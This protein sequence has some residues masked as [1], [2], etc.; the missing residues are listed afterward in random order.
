[1]AK[2]K[3]T[4]KYPL[5][6][7]SYTAYKEFIKRLALLHQ[8]YPSLLETTL[9]NIFT[10]RYIGNKTHGDMAEIGITEF[11]NNFLYDYDCEHVGKEEF[12]SKE[13]DEDI[14]VKPLFDNDEGLYIPISLKA[15]G[16]GPLQLSTDKVENPKDGLYHQIEK[17]CKNNV[18]DT[19][20]KINKVF[21]LKGFKSM[22]NV[23]PIIY[24][25]KENDGSECNI[26]TFNLAKAIRETCFI[27]HVK[28]GQKF[29]EKQ[30]KVITE[31]KSKRKKRIYPIFLFLN[32]DYNYICEVRYGGKDANALQRGIWA[33]TKK[34]AEYF[35]SFGDKW[36][37]YKK[38]E[39][40]LK[41]IVHA[42]N[43]TAE[44]HKKADD[45]LTSDIKERLP[46]KENE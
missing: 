14:V 3:K 8:R 25:E 11:I 42:L 15:Y 19:A 44:S 35:D 41:V 2:K 13:H 9:A 23:L 1:M 18:I 16:V 17:I 33:D 24:K 46:K 39:Q 32:K 7:N 20:E 22:T 30:K 5:M 12:R 34:G 28:K 31:D 4:G 6:E 43:S 38:Q 10:M 40:L 21:N 37:E 29:D 36:I 45:I 27:F 26:V